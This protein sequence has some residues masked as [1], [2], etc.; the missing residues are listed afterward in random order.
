MAVMADGF[1][2]L[3]A[4]GC[5]LTLFSLFLLERGGTCNTC[6]GVEKDLQFNDLD[7]ADVQRQSASLLPSSG[8][9]PVPD[10]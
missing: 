7:M 2:S 3:G 10:L 5:P 6:H 9:R 1:W 8:A 4:G